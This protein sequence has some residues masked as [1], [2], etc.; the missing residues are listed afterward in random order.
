MFGIPEIPTLYLKLAG[1]L[2][3]LLAIAGL[4]A[5]HNHAVSAA[6]ARGKADEA[7]HVKA[8]ALEIKSAA[9][10]MSSNISSLIRSTT[11][12]ENNHIHAAADALRLRG[13]GR[14]G[15]TSS[16]SVPTAPGGSEPA[17]GATSPPLARV[18]Y[19]EGEQLIGLPFAPTIGLAEQNDLNRAEALAWRDWW[20]K[21]NEAWPKPVP[22][23][24]KH[25]FLGL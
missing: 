15:C 9:D 25:H 11:D 13:P 19:P 14:A 22:P 23:K 1:G 21:Q 10:A 6:Y 2:L 24:K 12:A 3:A 16:S 7:E 5:W 8:K 17:S 4:I 18:P 20:K